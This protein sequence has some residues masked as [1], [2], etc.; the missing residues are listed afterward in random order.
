LKL[1]L[2]YEENSTTLPVLLGLSLEGTE[3]EIETEDPLPPAIQEFK[4]VVADEIAS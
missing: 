1:F 2:S 4:R 3:R